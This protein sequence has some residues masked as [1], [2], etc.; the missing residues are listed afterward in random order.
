MV[1]I[2]RLELITL[3]AAMLASAVPHPERQL[4]APGRRHGEPLREQVDR[5]ACFRTLLAATAMAAAF[6]G[7]A[8][9]A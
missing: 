1:T 8:P 5:A 6:T 9:P 4:A 7:L 2:N 3:E